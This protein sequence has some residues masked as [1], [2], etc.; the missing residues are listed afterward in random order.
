MSAHDLEYEEYH[1]KIRDI[2]DEREKRDISKTETAK[3]RYDRKEKERKKTPP[4]RG[5]SQ[6]RT[7]RYDRKEKKKYNRNEKEKQ[8]KKERLKQLKREHRNNEHHATDSET[9]S[10]DETDCV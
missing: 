8:Q 5:H 10:S 3:E 4:R 2:H 7:E 1:K 9:D 6:T